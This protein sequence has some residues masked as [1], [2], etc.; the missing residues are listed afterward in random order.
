[1]SEKMEALMQA[2]HMDKVPASWIK[3]SGPSQRT[4]GV[5]IRMYVW[6]CRWR[7]VSGQTRVYSSFCLTYPRALSCSHL[8]HIINS[9]TNEKQQAWLANLSLRLQQLEEWAQSP[10]DIPKVK[11]RKYALACAHMCPWMSL[12]LL[13]TRAWWMR[14]GQAC[15]PLR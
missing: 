3:I 14:K 7:C 11:R 15:R 6:T 9:A 2:L 12:C 13:C 5:R 4:L 1:M 10:G 8:Q